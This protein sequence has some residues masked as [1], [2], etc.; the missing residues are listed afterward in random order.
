VND[1]VI[2]NDESNKDYSSSSSA[3]IEN[4]VNN[5][6]NEL[7]SNNNNFKS[8]K[9]I[10]SKKRKS[11]KV[12]ATA[13]QSLGLPEINENI[14]EVAP[15]ISKKKSRKRVK[16]ASKTI[17]SLINNIENQN[18]I[19]SDWNN[20]L[21]KDSEK[22]QNSLEESVDVSLEI[23]PNPSSDKSIELVDHY[24]NNPEGSDR[25]SCIEHLHLQQTP[26][27]KQEFQNLLNKLTNPCKKSMFVSRDYSKSPDSSLFSSPLSDFVLPIDINIDSQRGGPSFHN[28]LLDLE[29]NN[30][31]NTQSSENPVLS[32]PN[33]SF[34]IQL[35]DLENNNT[36]TQS[37]ENPV[38][39]L[40]NFTRLTTAA[41]VVVDENSRFYQGII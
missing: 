33:H 3:V 18:T 21:L 10:R 15:V 8:E 25:F 1:S 37:S 9:V 22:A 39:S 12:V 36:N 4:A 24:L 7:N 2:V 17:N 16:K 13:S 28:Q 30:N 6:N 34:H 5:E 11:K 29:N 20:S 26:Q 31:T 35:L 40:P 41:D 27:N 32:L 38:L 14:S 23:Q 19:C